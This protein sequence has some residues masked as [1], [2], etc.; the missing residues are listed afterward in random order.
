MKATVSLRLGIPP[1]HAVLL[2][3]L[4]VEILTMKYTCDDIT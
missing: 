4:L 2:L 3:L 1:G